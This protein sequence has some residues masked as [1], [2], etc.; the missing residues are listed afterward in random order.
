MRAYIA[1]VVWLASGR[2]AQAESLPPVEQPPAE[3]AFEKGRLLAESGLYERACPAFELSHRLDPQFG[4]LFNLAGCYVKIGKIATAW[5]LYKELSQFDSNQ[6]RRAEAAR[7]VGELA[8]RVPRVQVGVR[9]DQQSPALR[10][11]VGDTEITSLLDVGIPFDPGHYVISASS[12]GYLPFHQR[13]YVHPKEVASVVVELEIKP[14][15]IPT[16]VVPERSSRRLAGTITLASSL[17]VVAFG[18]FAAWRWHVNDSN[19]GSSGRA[20]V[21]ARMSGT[22]SVIG[23]FGA[24]VGGGILAS[25]SGS[26]R[27]LRVAPAVDSDAAS[28]VFNGTF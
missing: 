18:L 19:D 4:T 20:D 21:W 1:V 24:V 12:P 8:P 7:L 23:V 6:Q 2:I 16:P 11:F 14:A 17:G 28:V 9:I 27:A 25:G 15:P 22:A 26:S 10:V 3:V 13:V 5:R